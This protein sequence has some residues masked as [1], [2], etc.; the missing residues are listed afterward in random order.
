V[1]PRLVRSGNQLR[2][3]LPLRAS[4]LELVARMLDPEH[5]DAR[6]A[7]ALDCTRHVGDDP[8]RLP[9]FVQYADLHVD[10]DED[11]PVAFADG[12]HADSSICCGTN[13]SSTL[14]PMDRGVESTVVCN[15]LGCRKSR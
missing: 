6:G 3:Q 11:A 15:S 1:D 4:G 8:L 5:R 14:G 2:H 7:G 9:C 10:D 12:C 13:A